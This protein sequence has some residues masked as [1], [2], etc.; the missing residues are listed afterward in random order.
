MYTYLKYEEKEEHIAVVTINR[1]EALNALNGDVIAELDKMV[2]ELNAK[3]DLR[4]VILTGEGRSFV[5]GADIGVQSVFDYDAA[6]NWGET[7]CRVFKKWEDMGVPTI[8]AVN[9]FALGG[10]CELA[11]SCDIIIA[12]EKAKF[13][14][15]EV[16]LGIT[17]GFAGTQRLTRKVGSFKA[18]ELIFTGLHISAAEAKEIGLANKVVPQEEVMEAALGMARAIAKNAPIAVRLAKEAINNVSEMG[19]EEGIRAENILFAKCYETEDQKVGMNA[20]LNK[21][22]AVFQ[23]K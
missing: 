4:A 15:P 1:P 6:L 7:G 19:L 11:L 17:P 14:Q 5:A 20:F 21:E 16:G 23:N 2:D 8:A 10:G 3:T 9:G 18:K 13:G 22:K 12:G